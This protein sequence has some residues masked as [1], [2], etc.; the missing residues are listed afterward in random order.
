MPAHHVEPEVAGA[1]GGQQVLA[2]QRP[3]P[4]HHRR[5]GQLGKGEAVLR[6][7]LRPPVD[8]HI[9]EVGQMRALH[10]AAI[11]VEPGNAARAAWLRS[12]ASRLG[13]R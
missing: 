3:E 13:L 7:E 2:P 4:G 8:I 10:L 1:A 6:R 12:R 9:E 11:R 5:T